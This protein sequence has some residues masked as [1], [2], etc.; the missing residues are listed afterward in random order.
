[1]K[2]NDV[3]KNDDGE[4]VNIYELL[5]QQMVLLAKK[6]KEAEPETLASLSAAMI[7]IFKVL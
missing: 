2:T 5:C 7:E 6:S 3:K 4:I 1:M